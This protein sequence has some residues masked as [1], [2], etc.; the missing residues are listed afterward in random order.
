MILPVEVLAGGVRGGT[1]IL[2]A[3][4]GESISERAGVVK[5]EATTCDGCGA[6]LTDERRPW[7]ASGFLGEGPDRAYY[8]LDACGPAC[9]VKALAIECEQ[10]GAGV[11]AVEKHRAWHQANEETR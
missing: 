1:S 3:A 5:I 2:Y 7:D 10:C 11:V 9:L 6:D 4:L 8:S